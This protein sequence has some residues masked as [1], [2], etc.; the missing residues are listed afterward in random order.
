MLPSLLQST[1]KLI[2]VYHL[3]RVIKRTSAD[4]QKARVPSQTG[5]AL[6]RFYINVGAA[7]QKNELH[8]HPKRKLVCA[9]K[10]GV[11]QQGR[12]PHG[13][14]CRAL[15]CTATTID[16]EPTFYS[17]FALWRSTPRK[18]S[19]VTLNTTGLSAKSAI[20]FGIAMRPL[21]V[22]AMFQTKSSEETL[23]TT[24]TRMNTSW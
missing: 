17:C 5:H 1:L 20:K 12:T 23:P 24:I 2:K 10:D 8:L 19:F 21:S 14:S 22:S 11:D 13:I 16:L 9:M 6:F 4:A 3:Q 15:F 7:N 18:Y